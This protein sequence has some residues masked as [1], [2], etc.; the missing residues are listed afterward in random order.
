MSYRSQFDGARS[1][2]RLRQLPDLYNTTNVSITFILH[3]DKSWTCAVI[4]RLTLHLWHT[5]VCYRVLNP[6]LR[7]R[8]RTLPD[9]GSKEMRKLAG[10]PKS[11]GRTWPRWGWRRVCTRSASG[12]VRKSPRSH[13]R[14]TD[15]WSKFCRLRALR[16][17]RCS[18][19]PPSQKVFK[20]TNP[21]TRVTGC[22][23]MTSADGNALYTAF[24]CINLQSQFRRL[25]VHFAIS[26][27]EMH[28]PLMSG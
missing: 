23:Y 3:N 1:S 20:K 4:K 28:D 14:W 18:A 22:A 21:C 17:P 16:W 25:Q 7:E 27:G 26:S 8:C 13:C 2:R 19:S 5:G 12:W 24:T 11:S 15:G 10:R 9:S 6:K